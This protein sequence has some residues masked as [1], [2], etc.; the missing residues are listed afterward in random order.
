[1]KTIF[2]LLIL[3]TLTNSFA[4]TTYTVNTNTP[5]SSNCSNCTFNISTGTT[6]TINGSVNCNNCT[7]N[8]G[9]ISIEKDMKCQPCS[10]NGNTINMNNQTL[11]P[12]SGTTSFT[13]V[14]FTVNGTGAI[15]ANTA[16]T[17]T[18]SIFTFNNACYFNNNGGQLDITNSKL[19]FN[20]NAYFNA[21]AGPVNLKSASKLVAGNGLLSSYA[22]I[23]I[24]GPV[25]NIY[26]NTSG[27]SLGNNNN[28]YFNWNAYNSISNTK[29]YATA[30]P[31]AANSLNCG[32]P[33]QNACGMWSAPTVYGPAALNSTGVAVISSILP[34][35]LSNDNTV[36][37][38]WVSLQEIN[39]SYFAIQ[40]SINGSAWDRIGVTA[41]KGN[42][43]GAVK[44]TYTDK[45]PLNGVAYYRLQ[46]VDNDGKIAY[47]DIKVIHASLVK[48][49]S[50]FPNPA[51]DYVNVALTGTASD[52]TVKLINQS[53]QVLRERKGTAGTGT[54][55]LNVQQYPRGM[56]ILKITAANGTEQTGKLMIAH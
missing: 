34:V 3:V 23:K 53:G 5:Y 51:V 32:A 18:N 11:K 9:N 19:Y 56:Y 10:F 54:V 36:V 24:N 1:M 49:I 15:E 45:T 55:S 12:N 21:N 16:V 14:N 7:F 33:G 17:I 25:L 2:T 42:S 22:Y 28:Y 39:T 52:I 27:I 6:L 26:D 40:R 30:Y 48:G 35:S 29:T 41:A 46:T 8:G 4:Q 37:I 31:N 50:F 43:S 13:N 47:S 20:D 44:Y 38:D